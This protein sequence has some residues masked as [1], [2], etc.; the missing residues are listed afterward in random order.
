MQQLSLVYNN[1]FVFLEPVDEPLPTYACG[2]FMQGS[3]T[4]IDVFFFYAVLILKKNIKI[5]I[6][7]K[8]LFML[9]GW[10]WTVSNQNCPN[11]HL[12]SM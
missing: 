11:A 9:F 8:H 10:G 3:S 7:I 12:L 4:I 1:L 6:Q 2:Q 5:A